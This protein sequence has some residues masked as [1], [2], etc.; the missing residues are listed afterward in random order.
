MNVLIEK[1]AYYNSYPAY[2]YREILLGG[3]NFQTI[4]RARF[5]FEGS[6]YLGDFSWAITR[7][8]ADVFE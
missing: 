7:M 4:S 3:S 2:V 1:R 8:L 5:E 6:E